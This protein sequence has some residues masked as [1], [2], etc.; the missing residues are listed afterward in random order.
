MFK[1][2]WGTHRVGAAAHFANTI[3]IAGGHYS[4]NSAFEGRG[5]VMVRNKKLRSNLKRGNEQMIQKNTEDDG[6]THLGYLNGDI[7]YNGA[8]IIPFKDA[9]YC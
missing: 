1:F 4:Q 7:I 9:L 5:I 2:P 8:A 3:I 6:W